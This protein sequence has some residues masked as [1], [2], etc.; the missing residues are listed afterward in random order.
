MPERP[1]SS[2]PLD[3]AQVVF[4][5]RPV[6]HGERAW[7]R[8][9]AATDEFASRQ[10]AAELRGYLRRTL[11]RG[12]AEQL[13]SADLE[14]LTQES[15]LRIHQK[16]GSFEEQS[17]FTTWAAAIAINC[18]LSELRRRRHQHVSIESAAAQ[19]AA[20]LTEE[21]A[22]S[23]P[24]ADA[25]LLRRA[26]DEA[27]TERQRQAI[28][29]KLGGLPLMELSRRLG[30]TPGAIYKLLHD[31]RRRLKQYLEAERERQGVTRSGAR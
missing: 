31:A 24:D 9:L 15:L 8:D 23:P 6:L 20:A 3:V 30:T 18:A 4:D 7:V 17:R 16:L 26:I 28:L 19:A 12:F 14:D 13:S 21:A 5:T 10:A 11:A 29:A 1:E 27:L 22:A 25:A 2:G